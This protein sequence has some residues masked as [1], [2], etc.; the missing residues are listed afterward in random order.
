MT[1]RG[2]ISRYELHA[3]LTQLGMDEAQAFGLGIYLGNGKENGNYCLGSR[4]LGLRVSG[5]K[6]LGF[7]GFGAV[8]KRCRSMSV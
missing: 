6:G 5:V 4:G 3:A 1:S 2:A 7:R 8:G